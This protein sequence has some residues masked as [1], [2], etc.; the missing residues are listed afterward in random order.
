MLMLR[1]LLMVASFASCGGGIVLIATWATM[2][3]H[4][5][6]IVVFIGGSLLIQGG[7]TILY[8][9]GELDRWG[10]IATGALF[11]GEGLSACVGAGGLIL[12]IIHNINHADMEMAPVLAGL[13]MLVQAV[14]A[15]LYLLVTNRLRPR[16]DGRSSA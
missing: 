15:L 12:G 9:H 11:A 8:L 3:Q 7:Y 4:V 10:E 6:P 16:I 13:L 14:L 2:W 1:L 5:P